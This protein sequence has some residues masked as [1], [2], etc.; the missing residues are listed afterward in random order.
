ME[1][2]GENPFHSYSRMC[3]RGWQALRVKGTVVNSLCFAGHTDSVAST[4]LYCCS[5]KA[6]T[7]IKE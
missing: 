2:K 5:S 4:Q 1:G 3:L 7:D 6:D